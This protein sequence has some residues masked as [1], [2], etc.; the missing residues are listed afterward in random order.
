MK[1]YTITRV[2]GNP[3]WSAIPS[4]SIDT[5]YKAD[6]YPIQ[7]W[8]QIAYDDE[9]L[10]VRLRAVEEHIRIEEAGP[11]ASTWEDSCLEFFFSP[12][13]GDPRY[14]NIETTCGGAFFI[15]VGLG[16]HNLFRMLPWGTDVTF[17]PKPTRVDGGWEISY[18]MPYEMLRL[19]FPTFAPK[20]GEILK[21]NCY[22][23]GNLAKI[24]HWMSWSPITAEK[25][26]FHTP[27]YFGTMIF[28]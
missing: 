26:D 13:E 6:S 27:Q 14:V 16:K 21:A 10:Y 20:S 3:D 8:A 12:I 22:K 23:C 24:P 19:V 4:L 5:P 15:G 1:T 25:L 7:A 18:R 28:E 17:E 2:N 11:L 9:N